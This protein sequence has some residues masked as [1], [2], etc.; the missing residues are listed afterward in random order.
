MRPIYLALAACGGAALLAH[1][2]GADAKSEALL[3]RARQQAAGWKSI[4]GTLQL[5]QSMQGNKQTFSA[6]VR[7]MKPNYFRMELRTPAGSMETISTGKEVYMVQ[8]EQKEYSKGPAPST[9]NLF[10]V[11]SSQLALF[12][13]PD[14]FGKDGTTRYLG[15]KQVNGKKYQVVLLTT[16][17]QPTSRKLFFGPTGNL[18][19][20]ELSDPRGM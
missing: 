15:A 1:A 4:S 12:F 16:K 11:P 2:A 9:G 13:E 10:G 3:K 17:A 19:G 5:G 6:T 18:E 7:A 14:K 8:P 20:V